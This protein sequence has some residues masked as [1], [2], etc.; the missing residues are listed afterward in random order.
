MWTV[1]RFR[2]N[3]YTSTNK[4]CIC[5]LCQI[6]K[7]CIVLYGAHAFLF[8]NDHFPVRL[9]FIFPSSQSIILPNFLLLL[10]FCIYISEQFSKLPICPH[11]ES[12]I[13]HKQYEKLITSIKLFNRQNMRFFVSFNWLLT[14]TQC[15]KIKT[16][17]F[18]RTT[19]VVTHTHIVR[20]FQIIV[21][22]YIVKPLLYYYIERP[23]TH[24][25]DVL[26]VTVFLNFV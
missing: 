10:H 8:F 24:V 19:H 1:R 16:Q 12:S 20:H 26:Y 9:S 17:T 3:P 22:Q 5:F 25:Y 21:T 23:H 18:I 7:I 15:S 14:I 4:H 6:K 2:V 11:F 13:D